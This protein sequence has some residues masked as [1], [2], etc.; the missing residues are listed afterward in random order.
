MIKGPIQDPER[1]DRDDLSLRPAREADL[2][3]IVGIHEAAFPGF[4]LT[5]LGPAFLRLYYRSIIE[6]PGCI[7][8]I[9]M[10]CE[11]P[12]GFVAG[13]L[14]PVRFYVHLRSHRVPLMLATA[15]KLMAEP[16]LLPRF[17][18]N[19]RRT[20]KRAV[21]HGSRLSELASLAVLPQYQGR[22][23]GRALVQEFIC[24]SAFQGAQSV[25]LTTDAKQNDRVNQ[26]YLRCGFHLSRTLNVRGRLLNEYEYELPGIPYAV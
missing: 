14:N 21:S 1:A 13:F 16:R 20:G 5:R 12:V 17:L 23:L 19:Y 24:V 6:Y 22:F 26:F 25:I 2:D 10:N 7:F 15:T 11:E 4:F 18:T 8:L 3:V 9:A